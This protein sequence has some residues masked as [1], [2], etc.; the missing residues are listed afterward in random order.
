M[1][2][3]NGRRTVF[4]S[5]DRAVLQAFGAGDPRTGRPNG[6]VLVHDNRAI[7]RYELLVGDS[8]AGFAAYESNQDELV[9]MHTEIERA[10]AGE[11]LIKVLVA[12]ALADARRQRVTI[13]AQCPVVRSFLQTSGELVDQAERELTK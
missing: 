2:S 10:Y 7:A 12:T 8:L 9:F 11:G 4:S 6:L 1:A 13:G 3:A 5:N